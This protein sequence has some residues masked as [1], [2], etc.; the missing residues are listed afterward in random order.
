MFFDR[1]LFL[2]KTL[3][4]ANEKG[5]RNF[6]KQKRQIMPEHMRNTCAGG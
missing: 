6:A 1:K 3:K 2:M 5:G 4:L